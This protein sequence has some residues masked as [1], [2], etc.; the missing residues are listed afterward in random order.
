MLTSRESLELTP[1][2][3]DNVSKSTVREWI[4]NAR[5]FPS[6]MPFPRPKAV[7]LRPPR[8]TLCMDG[9]GCWASVARVPAG[10]ATGKHPPTPPPSLGR[11]RVQGAT[12]THHSLCSSLFP[13]FSRRFSSIHFRINLLPDSTARAC[14]GMMLRARCVQLRG[15]A[16]EAT[17]VRPLQGRVV[18]LQGLPGQLTDNDL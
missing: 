2:D 7:R 3:I 11:L 6:R 1:T 9:I 13:N 14:A 18:L 4:H 5:E 12:A 8:S 15:R 16:E 10:I 17:C